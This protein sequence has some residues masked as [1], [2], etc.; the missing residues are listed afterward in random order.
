MNVIVDGLDSDALI[1]EAAEVASILSVPFAVATTYYMLTD[2]N[3]SK[4]VHENQ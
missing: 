3:L 4:Y 1:I 2:L